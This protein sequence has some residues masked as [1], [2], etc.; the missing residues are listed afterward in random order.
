MLKTS[1]VS[2]KKKKVFSEFRL[3]WSKGNDHTLGCDYMKGVFT[4]SV[5]A[6]YCLHG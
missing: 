3:Q 1:L 5:L 2:L 6:C 4:G